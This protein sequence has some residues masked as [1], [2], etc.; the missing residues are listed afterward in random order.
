[1]QGSVFGEEEVL[2]CS[3]FCWVVGVRS[4]KWGVKYRLPHW[5]QCPRYRGSVNHPS[6]S[7]L[8]Q[9]VQGVVD[10][11]ALEET[12]V[13]H[14]ASIYSATLRLELNVFHP[15]TVSWVLGDKQKASVLLEL[16]CCPKVS[17]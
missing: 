11:Q 10:T 16:N 3:H 12:L 9:S 5:G 4:D 7:A 1:M 15:S 17:P 8:G 6:S 2:A 14:A 13:S